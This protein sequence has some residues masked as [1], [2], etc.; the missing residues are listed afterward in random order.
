MLRIYTLSV[1]GEVREDFHIL[2][3][4]I[5]TLDWITGFL[6]AIIWVPVLNLWSI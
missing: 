2:H 3:F 1:L 4:S 5:V 6:T